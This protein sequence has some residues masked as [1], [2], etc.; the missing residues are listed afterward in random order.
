MA[1]KYK[2]NII[3]YIYYEMIIKEINR[4]L[5]EEE[6]DYL[7]IFTN[8]DNYDIN[9]AHELQKYS[10]DV[11]TKYSPFSIINSLVSRR[12][13]KMLINSNA[14]ELFISLHKYFAYAS[15]CFVYPN[16]TFKR[17]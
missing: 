5:N 4:E 3:F 9:S 2:Y 1:K 14:P 8:Y 10:W 13:K 15:L 12:A 11:G 17:K 16:G 6:L 7:M